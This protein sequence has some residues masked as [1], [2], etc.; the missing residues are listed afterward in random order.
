MTTGTEATEKK[1][2]GARK[3]AG[4]GKKTSKP[5]TGKPTETSE[6][7]SK[8]SDGKGL[9]REAFG[10][11]GARDSKVAEELMKRAMRGDPKST[12]ILAEMA[13]KEDEEKEALEHGPLRSQAME[14]AAEPPWQ[15][16]LETGK[17]ETGSGGREPE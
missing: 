17:G 4:A 3:K 16:E 8:K 1:K 15:G 2:S 9:D 11:L 13:K 10:A 14:W 7:G 6:S 5:R 12:N